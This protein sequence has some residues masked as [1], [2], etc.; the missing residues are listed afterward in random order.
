MVFSILIGVITILLAVLG[1]IMSS[2]KKWQR[3]VF[4]ILGAIGIT[5]IS[6]QSWQQTKEI[7]KTE[8]QRQ[9]NLE[10]QRR[11]EILNALTR[12]YILSHN[13]ISPKMMAGIE[14][15]P[16]DWI[17]KRLKEMNENWSY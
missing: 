1:G 15:P 3:M 4:F 9:A 17:N 6:L 5:L 16:R 14:K 7:K 13:G 12:E 8:L 10:I 11:N 2:N